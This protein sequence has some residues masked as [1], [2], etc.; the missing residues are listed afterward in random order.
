MIEKIV[1]NHLDQTLDVP[2]YMERPEQEPEEYVIVE[3]TGSS[4]E[5]FIKSATI[6]VKSHANSLLRAAE[7]NEQVKDAMDTIITLNEVCR[8]ELNSDYNFTDTETKKYRYQAVYDLV[9]Y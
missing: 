1:R 6:A 8:A 4:R 2:V 5:N 3:K 9:H 7:L